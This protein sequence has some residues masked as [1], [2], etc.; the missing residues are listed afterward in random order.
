MLKI[1]VKIPDMQRLLPER[2]DLVEAVSVNAAELI[3]ERVRDNFLRR[4][5]K[6]FWRAAA[7][8]VEV[9]DG[10]IGQ[11]FVTIGQRGVRLQWLGGVV[12]PKAP[13]KLLAIPTDKGI[14][15]MPRSYDNLV[16]V[17][18]TRQNGQ[19]RFPHLRGLLVEGVQE[20]AKRR[21]KDKPAGRAILRPNG[22]V[23]FRLVDE[24]HHLPHPDVMPTEEDLIKTA[25]EAVH[26]VLELEY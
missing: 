16:F 9:K 26:E 15:E 6:N 24:T 8:S 19:A 2:A 14:T 23:Y 5:G 1:E 22:K 10:G 25:E 7:D 12:R 17:P 21:Y 18:L 20:N 11:K 13:R 3:M 4:G